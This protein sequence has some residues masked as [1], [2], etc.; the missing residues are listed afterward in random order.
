MNKQ[1]LERGNDIQNL[2]YSLNRQL[3][4]VSKADYYL[5]KELSNNCNGKISS[6]LQD[7]EDGVKR[8]VIKSVKTRI[9]ALEKEFKKL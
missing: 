6:E 1:Q 3:E 4:L 8:T 7:L 2:L 5:L 9:D